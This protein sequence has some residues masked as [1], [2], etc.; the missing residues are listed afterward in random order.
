VRVILYVCL[1]LP[2]VPV[3]VSV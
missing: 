2:L 3:T 1:R